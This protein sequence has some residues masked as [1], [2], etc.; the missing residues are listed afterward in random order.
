MSIPASFAALCAFAGLA[1]A[2][3]LALLPIR[4]PRIRRRPLWA[5]PMEDRAW[6]LHV[7]AATPRRG[8][9]NAKEIGR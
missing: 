9:F 5:L 4:L 6:A 7:G 3:A 8:G 2:L 1:G